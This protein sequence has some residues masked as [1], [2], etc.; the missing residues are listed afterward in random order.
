[1]S[2]TFAANTASSNG[3]TIAPRANEP[4][5]PPCAAEP[6]SCEFAFAR[7]ANASGFA[8]AF[9]SSAV[10]F[11]FAAAL[12]ASDASGF[13]EIRMCEACRSSFV[14]YCFEFASYACLSSAGSTLI[15]AAIASWFSTRYSIFA[16]SGVLNAEGF[17][18]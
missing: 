10:A 6:V 2:P 17:L 3:F 4:R 1:M 8:S 13:T 5:S 18:S 9:W 15:C 16:S 11:C 12:S 7:S 14:V